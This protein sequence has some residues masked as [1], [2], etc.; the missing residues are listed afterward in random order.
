[1]RGVCMCAVRVF[2]CIVCFTVATMRYIT[3]KIIIILYSYEFQNIQFLKRLDDTQKFSILLLLMFIIYCC[4]L[5]YF[6]VF[7]PFHRCYFFYPFNLW[8]GDFHGG[9]SAIKWRICLEPCSASLPENNYVAWVNRALVHI[10]KQ[11]GFEYF[12]RSHEQWALS[13]NVGSSQNQSSFFFSKIVSAPSIRLVVNQ[14][15][16]IELW[17]FDACVFANALTNCSFRHEDKWR[18]FEIKCARR[19]CARLIQFDSIL[20]INFLA[21]RTITHNWHLITELHCHQPD[22]RYRNQVGST[23]RIVFVVRLGLWRTWSRTKMFVYAQYKVNIV[24]VA[25]TL[26]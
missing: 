14:D 6:V 9:L 13:K 21:H 22:N 25:V 23:Q 2:V 1:M 20:F 11:L 4:F 7:S 16:I 5:F 17:Q 26:V 19:T 24:H 12:S 3:A 8:I 10:F 15:R 18:K